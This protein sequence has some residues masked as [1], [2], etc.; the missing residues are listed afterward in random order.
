MPHLRI[1]DQDLWDAAQ[2]TRTDRAR[3]MFGPGGLTRRTPF[4][5]R[6]EHL[7]AGM[8]R[9]GV[10]G[11]PM[12][13]RSMTRG[14]P[15][16]A[17][18]AAEKLGTCDHDRTYDLDRLQIAVLDGMRKRLTDPKALTEAAREYH[19]EW[20][21]R[22][23][24]NRVE[25][26]SVRR[27]LARV[28]VSMDRIVM[29][30]SDPS[31]APVAALTEK[32]KQLETERVGLSERLRL[33]EAE[34][35]VVTLHPNVLE[36]Y[37]LTVERMHEALSQD[38]SNAENRTAFRNLIDSI[39]IHPIGGNSATRGRRRDYEFTTYGRLSA[40]LGIDLFPTGRSPAEILAEQGVACAIESDRGSAGCRISSRARRGSRCKGRR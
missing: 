27:R 13:I 36:T 39:A 2:K 35:N 12:R 21:R 19:A 20:A 38:A 18:T 16:A 32:L 22:E 30:I 29:A 14:V 31:G 25:A 7:L 8:V 40:I 9:C 28:E 6:S 23:K 3:K 33:V 26:E 24:Q 1:V 5:A 11:S 34:T 15:Y 17:C 10:C 37:E 4:L